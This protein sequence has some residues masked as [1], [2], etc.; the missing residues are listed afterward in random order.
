MVYSCTHHRYCTIVQI[1]AIGAQNK[2]SC[3]QNGT[4]PQN[5]VIL[6]AWTAG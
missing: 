6:Y 3:Y 5:V 1:K 4:L 2:I